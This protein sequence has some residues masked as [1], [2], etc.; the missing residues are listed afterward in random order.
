MTTSDEG[1]V[2][3]T[4]ETDGNY[5][6]VNVS[7]QELGLR[8]RCIRINHIKLRNLIGSDDDEGIEEF[9]EADVWMP[10]GWQKFHRWPGDWD[11][12]ET[13]IQVYKAL[14]RT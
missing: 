2:A 14:R 8:T 11:A 4:I 7:G 9:T 13:A 1:I 10:T 12:E 3:E 5:T 6:F